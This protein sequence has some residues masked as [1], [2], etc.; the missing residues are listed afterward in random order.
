[1]NSPLKRGRDRGLCLSRLLAHDGLGGRIPWLNL[2]CAAV[3]LV[4]SLLAYWPVLSYNFFWEDPFNIGQVQAYIYGQ[5]LAAPDS[6][7]YYRPLTLIFSMR[8][9]TLWRSRTGTAWPDS[10]R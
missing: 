10:F 1:M 7:S 2:G 9:K 5:L 8:V 4:T 6:N 3:V